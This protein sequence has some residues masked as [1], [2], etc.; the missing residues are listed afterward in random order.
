M[1]IFWHISYYTL[2]SLTDSIQTRDAGFVHPSKT[3]SQ[4]KSVLTT[5]LTLPLYPT[6]I[7][8]TTFSKTRLKII[9]QNNALFP[10]ICNVFCRFN[11]AFQSDFPRQFVSDFMFISGFFFYKLVSARSI[12]LCET[13]DTSQLTIHTFS[14]DHTLCFKVCVLYRIL[15]FPEPLLYNIQF[16]DLFC[17]KTHFIVIL[18]TS[19][20]VE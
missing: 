11:P 19:S 8:P 10:I 13:R 7:V 1:P 16:V 14:V 3:I 2:L 4:A 12:S 17:S 9:E 6:I 5:Y 15:K 20:S 18:S